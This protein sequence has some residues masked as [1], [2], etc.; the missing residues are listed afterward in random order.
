MEDDFRKIAFD[1]LL[2]NPGSD[3]GDWQDFLINGYGEEVVDEFGDN[4]FDVFAELEDYWETMDY[5]DPRT[6][7]FKTYS[8]W[9]E[10]F[11]TPEAVSIYNDLIDTHLQ[12]AKWKEAYQNW[13]REREN[14]ENTKAANLD[15]LMD[16]LTPETFGD[17]NG[18]TYNLL[19]C[20]ERITGKGRLEL[21]EELDVVDKLC[22]LEF[23]LE[24][25]PIEFRISDKKEEEQDGND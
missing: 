4:P 19:F 9:A 13:K 8:Q 24:G 23:E 2:E 11:A 18:A 6:G 7:I 21:S 20:I 16:S 14:E 5:E 17:L 10:A 3:F 25:M 22:E 12:Y 15:K 1:V